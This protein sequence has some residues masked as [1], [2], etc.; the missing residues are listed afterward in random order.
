MAEDHLS[1]PDEH[2][3]VLYEK[4]QHPLAG[5]S[6]ELVPMQFVQMVMEK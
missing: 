1:L 4:R 3:M 5:V 6:G 2:V